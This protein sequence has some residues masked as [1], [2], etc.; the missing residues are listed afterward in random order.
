MDAAVK[1]RN[2]KRKALN[3][4]PEFQAR[5]RAVV[6]AGRAIKDYEEKADPQLTKLA[7]A[8]K[9]YTD[10]VKSSGLK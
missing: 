10:S 4:N 7:D 9:A 3:D 2:A 5:N 1:E 6:D 8:A